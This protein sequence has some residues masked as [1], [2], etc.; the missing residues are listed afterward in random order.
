MTPGISCCKFAELRRATTGTHAAEAGPQPAG[1]DGG[2]TAAKPAGPRERAREEDGPGAAEAA[3][4][5]TGPQ[6]HEAREVQRRARGR[7]EAVVKTH[8]SVLQRQSGWIP[9]SPD[10]GRRAEDRDHERLGHELEYGRTGR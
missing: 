6:V 9:Q 10:M 1:A 2:R 5:A 8:E 4:R 7:V 3:D